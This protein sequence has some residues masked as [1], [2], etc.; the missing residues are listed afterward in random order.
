MK[1]I[2]SATFLTIWGLGSTA[3]AQITNNGALIS[4]NGNVIIS[5]SMD[6][7][8]SG[9]MNIQG[10]LTL[11]GKR[12]VSAEKDIV[13]DQ[14]SVSDRTQLDGNMLIQKQVDFG[15][16][17]LIKVKEDRALT[18]GP[19][20]NYTNYT[21]GKGVQG[22]VKKVDAQEFVFPL[23]TT[24]E[25]FPVVIKE[26]QSLVE[27]GIE[28][29]FST[30]LGDFNESNLEM[31]NRVAIKVKG[32]SDM[33]PTQLK[34]NFDEQKEEVVLDKGIWVEANKLAATK[35]I[36]ATKA[37][38]YNRTSA[39]ETGDSRWVRVFPNPSNGEV[40]VDLSEKEAGAKVNF[41]VFDLSGKRLI[42]EEKL[43]SDWVNQKTQLVNLGTGSYLLQ[44]ESENGKKATLKHTLVR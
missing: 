34:L 35:T 23:G 30:D 36:V 29:Q 44:F 6:I 41:Q 43:G 19:E 8:N 3:H 42:H 38:S 40:T 10:V 31:P 16:H 1:R 32:S 21:H 37:M 22:I 5:S 33:Q 25:A 9:E 2:I 13:V 4:G 12:K 26:K 18:F 15:A 39:L 27:A 20:A 17:G 24:T 14:L 11:E 7:Q 28:P